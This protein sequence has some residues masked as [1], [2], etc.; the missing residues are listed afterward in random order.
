MK[1][2][3]HLQVSG[4]INAANF[5]QASGEGNFYGITVKQTTDVEYFTGIKVLSFN[6]DS[7][8]ISQNDPNTDE[9]IVNF[10]G[11]P[12]A[13]TVP[14]Q[15]VADFYGITV[16]QTSGV[17]SF[18]GIKVLAFND[19]SFYISQNDPNTDEVIINFRGTAGSGSG[20]GVSQNITVTDGVNSHLVE[21]TLNFSISD[22]YISTNLSGQ[23][24]VNISAP[25]SYVYSV[26]LA[27]LGTNQTTG[28]EL[29]VGNHVKWDTITAQRGGLIKLNTSAPYT[30][31]AGASV[32]RFTLTA[33]R[34]Y[35]I[36]TDIQGQT[37]N[38]TNDATLAIMTE[39]GVTTGAIVG[40]RFVSPGSGGTLVGNS[41]TMAVVTPAVDTRYEVRITAATGLTGI[42][43]NSYLY[44]REL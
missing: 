26:L 34:T 20:S 29:T 39:S 30:T 35:S 43:T 38:G 4:N 7:F 23:P 5:P 17:E 3:G 10:R 31:V 1:L 9:V 2:K 8:Y 42:I 14:P 13:E 28:S 16:K 18:S 44:V 21:D 32:G 37:T 41:T 12:T 40:L 22:F 6:N 24:V 25:P 15:D 33:G 27:G 11:T 36:F 19:D